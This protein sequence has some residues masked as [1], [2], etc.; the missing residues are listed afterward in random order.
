MTAQVA[1]T[2][3]ERSSARRCR[4]LRQRQSLR[5]SAPAASDRL[6][7]RR[8]ATEPAPRQHRLPDAE[9]FG[10]EVSRH[11]SLKYRQRSDAFR[12]DVRRLDDRPPFLDLGVLISTQRLRRL[13]LA[14]RD[15]EPLGGEGLMYGWIAQRVQG[16]RV[17]LADD[18]LRRA[19]GRK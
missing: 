14:R 7:P 5:S 3:I 6:A 12:L 4:V 11:R 13:P 10:G 19:P 1:P 15:F 17:E 8:S 2:A 16:R 9:N 18:V